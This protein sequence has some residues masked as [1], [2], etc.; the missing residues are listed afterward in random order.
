MSSSYLDHEYFEDKKVA[1][2]FSCALSTRVKKRMEKVIESFVSK[3]NVQRFRHGG[4]W[5]HP[6]NPSAFNGG[7]QAHSV[8]GTTP[9]EDIVNNDLESIERGV[10]QL[11]DGMT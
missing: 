7:I 10:T 9:F 4:D 1:K 11:A 5:K 3:E 2:A 8:E 6:A